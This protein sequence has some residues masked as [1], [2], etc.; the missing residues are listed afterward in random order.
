[1]PYF[2]QGS[3]SESELYSGKD[4]SFHG[5][6]QASAEGLPDPGLDAGDCAVYL[7]SAR[8]FATNR[9][10]LVYARSLVSVRTWMKL[11]V[12][13]DYSLSDSELYSNLAPNLLTTQHHAWVLSLNDHAKAISRL[14]SW[15][16]DWSVASPC[17]ALQRSR[18]TD[19][20]SMFS[21]SPIHHPAPPL[22]DQD[23]DASRGLSASGY[24]SCPSPRLLELKVV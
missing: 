13:P 7:R 9:S 19:T 16:P 5:S 15:V 8:F 1:M 21:T 3:G 11:G 10:D 14:P 22:H 17:V 6:L 23:F 12:S 4:G 2:I 24:P 18:I 20:T